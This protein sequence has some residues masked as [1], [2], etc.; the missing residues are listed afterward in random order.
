[1]ACNITLSGLLPSCETNRGGVDKIWI[2]EYDNVSDI[3]FSEDKQSVTKIELKTGTKMYSYNI[4]KQ[5]TQLVSEFTIDDPNGISFSTNTLNLKFSRQDAQK[6]AEVAALMLGECMVLVKD[7]NGTYH[8]LGS[9]VPV[10][11]SAGSADTG[12]A[13]TDANAYTLALYDITASFPPILTTAIAE[14]LIG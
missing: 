12:T 11:A 3:T 8:L 6:R 9:E 7:G 2:I 14:G 5:S 10:T 4:R 1:M 13:S